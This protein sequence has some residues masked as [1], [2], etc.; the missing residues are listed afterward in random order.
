MPSLDPESNVEG[1]VSGSLQYGL[2]MNDILP[3]E[4]VK[5]G[6]SVVTS[7]LGGSFPQGLLIGTITGVQGITS[8]PFKEA[9]VKPT[10]NINDLNYVFVIKEE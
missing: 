1:V 9:F 7:G 6:D 5:T 10:L 3:D 8:Q 4:T 2:V